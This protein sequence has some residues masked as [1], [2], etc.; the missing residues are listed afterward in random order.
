MKFL[1]NIEIVFTVQGRG[2]VIVPIWRSDVKIRVGDR[3][4]LQSSDG[5]IRDTKIAG[6]EML[7]PVSEKCR[8]A[9]ILARDV[10]KDEIAEGMEIWLPEADDRIQ[11]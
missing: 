10:R 8:A 5:R 2:T 3:I 11:L 7:K 6:V 1:G 4:R 9:F